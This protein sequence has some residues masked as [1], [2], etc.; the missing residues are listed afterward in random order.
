MPTLRDIFDLPEHVGAGDFVLKLT[1]GLNVPAETV[2]QYVVTP[3]LLKCF[4]QALSL[5]H[6]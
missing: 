4:D 6:I 5:I 1:D 2:R 3:Q